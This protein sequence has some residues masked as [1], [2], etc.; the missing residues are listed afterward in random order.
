MNQTYFD[1]TRLLTQ[2]ALLFFTDGGSVLKDGTA[3]NRMAT[4]VSVL[5]KCLRPL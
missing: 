4:P 3:I 2:V 1:N 5:W